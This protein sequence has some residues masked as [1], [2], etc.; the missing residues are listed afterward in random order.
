M[1][2]LGANVCV[3]A[4]FKSILWV[5][6]GGEPGKMRLLSLCLLLLCAFFFLPCLFL[7]V[8]CIC[9]FSLKES[10]CAA[11]KAVSDLHLEG[12]VGFEVSSDSQ[13]SCPCH[14]ALSLYMSEQLEE[15]ERQLPSQ[16]DSL[17]IALTSLDDY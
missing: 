8:L 10:S 6:L 2:V 5:R 11:G 17:S 16:D 1:S 7:L 3:L 4:A 15:T 9:S 12:Q 14:L 13:S